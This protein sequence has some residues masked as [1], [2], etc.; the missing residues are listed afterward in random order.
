MF[1]KYLEKV[2]PGRLTR[3]GGS[4][5]VRGSFGTTGGREAGRA[6]RGAAAGGRRF[7]AAGG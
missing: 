2:R 1:G 6:R 3:R 7:P 4:G 5:K